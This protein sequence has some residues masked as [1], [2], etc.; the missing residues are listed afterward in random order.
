MPWTHAVVG[1]IAFSLTSHALARA[2]P[3]TRETALV[4]FGALLPD[5]VD[6]PLAW[7]F[8]LFG[9][10]T[11]A[12]S[13]FVAVPLSAAAVAAAARR[14]RPRLGM[15]FATGY[16]L[17]LPGDLLPEFL[18]TG[19][20]EISTLLWP[21]TEGGGG[22]SDSFVREFMSNVGPYAQDIGA[23]ILAG[24]LSGQL[25]ALLSLWGLT[26]ALWVYDGMPVFR[27]GYDWLRR[28]VAQ[29]R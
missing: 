12:H 28:T 19:R 2:A 20:L 21:V 18:D 22:R 16:L 26:F 25:L 29:Q 15:A 8:G 17:H 23:A 13:V 27:D 24:E 14:G 1:Y 10:R 4:A 5:L 9:G 6:K 11:L 3:S 7:Q